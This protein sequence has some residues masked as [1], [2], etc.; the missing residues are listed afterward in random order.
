MPD[1]IEVVDNRQAARFEVR[2]NGTPAGFADYILKGGVIILPHTEVRP[3][4]RGRGL[5]GRLAGTALE[6]A[7]D[8]GLKVIPRCPYIADYIDRH[9]EYADLV[10][11][12]S[13]TTPPTSRD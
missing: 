8:A 12:S 6:A 1:A 7:R 4:F 13:R 2:L 9:P 5:A 10:A 3:E 11:G